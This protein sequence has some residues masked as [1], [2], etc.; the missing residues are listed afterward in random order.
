MKKILII[1]LRRIGDV[2]TTGHLIN[3]LVTNQ[4]ASVSMLVYSESSKAATHLKNVTSVFTI[5]RKEIITL[6][7]N[8]LF[9]DGFALEQLLLKLDPIKNDTWDE[10]INYS[11][12]PVAAYLCS[13][14][15][16]STGKITGV[17]YNSNKSAVVSDDWGMLFNDILPTLPYA[18][19][20]FVDCY[21]R[22]SGIKNV[23]EGEKLIANTMYNASAFKNMGALRKKANAPEGHAK[24]VGIHLKSSDECKDLSETTLIELIGLLRKNDE[25][26]PLLLI[27]PFEDERKKASRINEHF[28]N[29][30]HIAEANLQAIA[31]I[32]TNID[33]LITPDTAIKHIA[34][35]TDTPVLEVSLGYA[36][37]L[38]QGAYSA[39]SLI[40][41]DTLS[42]RNF[43]RASFDGPSKTNIKAFDIVSSVFYFFAKSKN[44]KPRLSEGVTLYTAG[45]DALGVCYQVVAGTHSAE[46]EMNRLMSRQFISTLLD[47]KEIDGINDSI[48]AI[49]TAAVTNWS[50]KE[51]TA[52]TFVTKD[53]LAT[54]RSLIQSTENKNATRDF[55]SNLGRLLTHTESDSVVKIPV[56]IFKV[57]LERMNESSFDESSRQ[58]EALLYNLKSD[59]QKLLACLKQL[60]D[61][62]TIAKKEE[63]MGRVIEAPQT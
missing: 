11:N 60:E 23:R 13:Y 31:S 15:K 35:L 59:I 47:G 42:S 62:T 25:L 27:G 17:S 2:Y 32:L 51:K 20:H 48:T 6:K 44:I 34:D 43:S 3:S 50:N 37:F 16:N 56:N 63:F 57:K 61:K 7:T 26:I 22:M 39:G 53:L 21:H 9:S 41:T 12:D 46:L 1:N 28:N 45:V 30:L 8:K 52:I 49:G 40:L 33:L 38:K 24:I 14:L 54:L 5:D 4:G 36:P 55:V 29:E 58:V 19:F 10:V 18:P